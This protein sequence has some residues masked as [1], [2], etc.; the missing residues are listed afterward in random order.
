MKVQAVKVKCGKSVMTSAT[1]DVSASIELELQFDEAE[2]KDPALIEKCVKHMQQQAAS[3]VE[4]AINKEIG[5][6]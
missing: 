5:Q 3:L 1:G 6:S 4:Q 2:S